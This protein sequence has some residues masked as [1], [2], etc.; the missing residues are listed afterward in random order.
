MLVSLVG[1][2]P[3]LGADKLLDDP[4]EVTEPDA[5]ADVRT[6]QHERAGDEIPRPPQTLDLVL[7]PQHDHAYLPP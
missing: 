3:T 7:A 5:D 6:Y 1:G 2:F 4:V